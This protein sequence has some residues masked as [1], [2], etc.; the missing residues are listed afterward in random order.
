[1]AVLVACSAEQFR[2]LGFQLRG[3]TGWDHS[4]EVA[5]EEKFRSVFG[6]NSQVIESIW[7]EL[8]TAGFQECRINTAI[9]KPLHLLLTY[10]WLK[11]YESVKELHTG[12]NMAENT[13][14]K[15]IRMVLHKIALLRKIK[16][17]VVPL[18]V[19]LGPSPNSLLTLPSST[20]RSELAGR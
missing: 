8:Q 15:H 7:L 19:V 6:T 4:G 5:Q 18:H 9:T 12:F 11:A 13:I 14:R 10:Q 3:F 1:M 20:D 17:S 2:L 16:V